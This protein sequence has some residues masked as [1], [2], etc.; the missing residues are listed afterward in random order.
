MASRRR[1]RLEVNDRFRPRTD[2]AFLA[3]VVAAALR[4][5]GRTSM[6]VSLLLADDREIARLHARFLG[7]PSRTDVISFEMD[8][9]ADIA[10]SVECARREA[11]RRGHSIRA[12]L[13]LYVVHGILHACGHDDVRARDR[14]RMREAERAVLASL[15][16]RVAPVDD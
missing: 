8:G 4:H 1:I 14:A 7:D 6:P 5:E 12:E 16:L 13:A 2:R 3:R 10:V 15:G 11:A 9:A